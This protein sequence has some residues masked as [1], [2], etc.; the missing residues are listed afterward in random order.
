[1]GRSN[2]L[3]QFLW[4]CAGFSKHN[5]EVLDQPAY[6]IDHT[7][8]AS[9][10]SAVLATTF[11]AF[12]TGT[13]GW[14]VV[15]GEGWPAFVFGA[16]WALIIFGW[17]RFAVSL[18]RDASIS[19]LLM[20]I[21]IAAVI[22]LTMSAPIE[23]YMLQKEI[24]SQLQVDL[25][26]KAL[27]LE[28]ELAPL[29]ARAELPQKA[30]DDIQIRLDKAQARA[31]DLTQQ[32]VSECDGTAGSKKKGDGSLCKMK[33]ARADEAK[34]DY[35]GLLGSSSVA[36]TQAKAEIAS[37]HGDIETR[38]AITREKQEL[39]TG[40]FERLTAMHEVAMKNSTVFSY[41]I[42]IVM[43][44]LLLDVGPVVYKWSAGQ[45]NYD[46]YLQQAAL[47][48][49]DEQRALTEMAAVD[50]VAKI[51]KHRLIAEA[52]IATQ[53]KE[54]STASPSSQALPSPEEIR[55]HFGSPVVLSVT[56][57]KELQKKLAENGHYE[58][59]VDGIVGYKTIDAIKDFQQLSGFTID[60]KATAQVL[61][62]LKVSIEVKS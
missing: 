48:H 57:V 5:R 16:I 25:N 59:E 30:L 13:Y 21:L 39:S 49:H 14:S 15:V 29:Y 43:L 51:A 55:Q 34:R 42:L 61:D 26:K 58:G 44:M 10:G 32:A 52:D 2:F 56:S 27:E 37:I 36:M 50:Q 8:Y 33:M 62:K 17:D 45:T 40:L 4:F 12:I 38:K 6:H 41:A 9:I 24:H 7:R 35:L 54:L 46:V 28:K 20:R 3:Y 1:M 47:R 53:R 23:A 19:A 18:P 11:I 60:G 31:D 22:A